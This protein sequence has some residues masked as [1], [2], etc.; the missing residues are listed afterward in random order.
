MPDHFNTVPFA[1]EEDIE[2]MTEEEWRHVTMTTDFCYQALMAGAEDNYEAIGAIMHAMLESDP[3]SFMWTFAGIAHAA[4]ER[5]AAHEDRSEMD[6]LLELHASNKEA[7]NRP[8][9]G[10]HN[11]N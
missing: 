11:K 5:V 9:P 4:I 7:M 2:G 10:T 6:L 3:R 8:P 1:S